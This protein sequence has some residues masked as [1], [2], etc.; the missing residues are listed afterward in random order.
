LVG[1]LLRSVLLAAVFLLCVRYGREA[2]DLFGLHAAD[3]RGRAALAIYG[4]VLGQAVAAALLLLWVKITGRGWA[5]LGLT[6]IGSPRAWVVAGLVSLAWTLLVWNGV[7]RGVQGAGELSLWRVGAALAAG[8]IG[9]SCEELVFRGAVIQS[10]REA[11]GAAWVQFLM[12][13]LLFGLAH[14]GWASLSGN[15]ASGAAAAVVT[16]VLGAALSAVFFAGGRSLWP[17]IF[18][19]ASINMAI[20]PWLVLTMMSGA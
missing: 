15:L 7:L 8:L 1:G 16:G 14:L 6:R 10:I 9:G 11:R 2:L 3:L 19:H 20:E 18:A 12:G 5:W 13:S 17:C 4:S